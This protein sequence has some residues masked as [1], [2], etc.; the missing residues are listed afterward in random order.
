MNSVINSF[1][2]LFFSLFLP[3]HDL[4]ASYYFSLITFS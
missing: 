2:F 3:Y 4:N 1:I